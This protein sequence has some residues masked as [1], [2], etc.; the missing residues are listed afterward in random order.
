MVTAAQVKDFARLHGA[1]LVGIGSMDRFEGAPPE[2]DPRYIF[3]EA[4]A[5]VGL[6]FRVHRGCFRG[7]EE[8]T[9]FG[10]Y[11]SMGYAGINYRDAPITLRAVCSALEDEG[12]EA[13]PIQNMVF[14]ASIS[15]NDGSPQAVSRAVAPD[16]P[17]PDVMMHFRIGAVICG[18]GEIGYS[19]MFLS[20]QFGPRQ[21]LAFLLTDAPLEPDPIFEGQICDRCKLCVH[22]C[23]VGAFSDTETVKVNIAGHEYEWAKLDEKKCS[24]GY[25]GANPHFSPFTPPDYDTDEAFTR[26]YAAA[27]IPYNRNSHGMFHLPGALEGA[28][29]C[30]RACFMHLEETGRVSNRFNS[31][32]RKR[33]PWRLD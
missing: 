32:F 23:T 27:E 20:P 31:P 7:I 11:P 10:A 24:S 12:Y 5:I 17:A 21:R 4:K 33:Q 18:M 8:G 6:G 22:N 16:R 1:D 29:G 13:V 14:M 9:Y 19:K 26:F 3:P 28:R 2:M 25:Q 30:M 15:P